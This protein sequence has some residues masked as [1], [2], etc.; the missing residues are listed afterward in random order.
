MSTIAKIPVA[1]LL[2]VGAALAQGSPGTR[3]PSVSLAPPPK[4][5]ITRGKNGTV[6]L[7]LRVATGYH[8]NSNTPKSEFLIPTTLK[9]DAL[10]DFMAKVEY[11]AGQD[12]SFAFAPQEK[13][14]VY[15]GDF[16][17]DVSVRPLRTVQ[18]GNYAFHGKLRY[19]ACDNAACYP[20][21]ELPVNF[22]VKVIKG[23]PASSRGN[24]KQSP[25]I[26]K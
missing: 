14:N 10:T 1:L 17:L 23:P 15:S 4:I 22:E 11:P 13:L 2:L 25:H 21:K 12:M 8:I 18:A 20:P 6:P 24:P 19:Q 16:N 7:Q 26:H 5:T 9:L 3:A